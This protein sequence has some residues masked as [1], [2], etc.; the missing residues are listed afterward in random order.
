MK[1]VPHLSTLRLPGSFLNA[2]PYSPNSIHR[3]GRGTGHGEVFQQAKVGFESGNTAVNLMVLDFVAECRIWLSKS[4]ARLPPVHIV[5]QQYIVLFRQLS[6][7]SAIFTL[8]LRYGYINIVAVKT[9]Y[10]TLM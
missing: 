6:R 10:P 7:L 9:N 2:G 3:P 1:T 8:V 5:V 4:N